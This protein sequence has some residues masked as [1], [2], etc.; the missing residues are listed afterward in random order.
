MYGQFEYILIT[1]KSEKKNL[2]VIMLI[3]TGSELHEKLDRD[4]YSTSA[5][6]MFTSLHQ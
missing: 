3:P 2:H 1:T 5:D 4:Q 6:V